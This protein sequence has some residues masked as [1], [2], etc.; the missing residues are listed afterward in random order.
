MASEPV[1]GLLLIPSCGI[2]V[3]F[4]LLL[5]LIL[6][7]IIFIVIYSM[8]TFF[9]LKCNNIL[10]ASLI[11]AAIGIVP[12]LL[13]SATYTFLRS[14]IVNNG[15]TDNFIAVVPQTI[16]ELLSPYNGLIVAL[17][18]FSTRGGNYINI[19][20]D[21]FFLYDAQVISKISI[22]RYFLIFCQMMS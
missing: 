10:D 8:N 2:G 22:K 15:M 13:Y 1:G 6:A 9:I 19:S 11:S 16:I 18:P 12:V 7:F 21:G 4:E 5:V 14:Q 17:S 20:F 3:Y